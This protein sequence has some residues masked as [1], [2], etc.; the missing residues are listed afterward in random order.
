[1]YAHMYACLYVC[2]YACVN[3]CMYLCMC[4]CTHAYM[5]VNVLCTNKPFAEERG[6]LDDF[7]TCVY[8]CMYACMY[9]YVQM[10]R[11][12]KRVEVWTILIRVYMYICMYVCTYIRKCADK[13][14]VKERGSLED[15]SC[16]RIREYIYIHMYVC[17]CVCVRVMHHVCASVFF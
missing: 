13:L 1:M 4:K 3:V 7:D 12:L 2:M 11:V 10:N 16:V 8:V 15:L 5:F 6:S 17:V 14:S 9:V